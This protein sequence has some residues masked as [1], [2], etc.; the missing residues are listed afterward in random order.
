MRAPLE[1]A[2]FSY[3]PALDGIRGLL[4]FPVL[5]YHFT[6]F[7]SV[8]GY[9]VAIGSYLA[10]SMFFTLSGF[11]ITSL[12]LVE[13][14]NTGTVD[15]AKFWDRRFRRL[16]PASVC[17][18]VAAVAVGL[19]F[20][21]AW[22]AL[23]LDEIGATT[24]SFKNWQSIAVAQD[25]QGLRNLGPLGPYWSLALEEQFYLG[26]SLVVLIATRFLKWRTVL[27]SVLV[28]LWV[29]SVVRATTMS[30]SISRV[31]FGTDVRASELVAGC[32]FAIGIDR[33]GWPN[34][35][36]I[37]PLGWIALLAT[38]AAWVWLP[39]DAPL[40]L[41]GGLVLAPLLNLPMIAAAGGS[42]SLFVRTFSFRPLVELGKISYPVYLV[43]W[44]IT[45]L[46]KTE[47]T[48]LSGWPLIILCGALSVA[49]AVPLTRW[50]EEP[51]RR[52]RILRGWHFYVLWIGI[53][54]ALLLVGAIRP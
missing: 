38:V 47:I 4:V 34:R 16:I 48:G 3:F 7:E 1:K 30:G 43:H 8:L 49:C 24:L 39:E 21:R 33:F 9:R 29:G 18:V 12:L 27:I 22:P 13:L 44:P 37:A 53:V 28:V 26:L 14:R 23:A 42:Q 25:G 50:I 40:M 51:I 54:A 5:L 35:R 17:V 32:L 11:L 6:F 46:M 2:R 45:V 31:Y 36:W 15:W 10:P 19:V 52:G 20:S 41:K